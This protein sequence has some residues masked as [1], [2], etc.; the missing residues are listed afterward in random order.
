MKCSLKMHMYVVDCEFCLMVGFCQWFVCVYGC[1]FMCLCVS[2]FVW[3]AKYGFGCVCVCVCVSQRTRFPQ[4]TMFSMKDSGVWSQYTMHLYT[5]IW[6]KIRHCQCQCTYFR[7][8][9]QWCLANWYTHEKIIIISSSSTST[10]RAE[11]SSSKVNICISHSYDKRCTIR[12]IYQ[13]IIIIYKRIRI[14]CSICC[15]HYHYYYCY[16]LPSK[17]VLH[18]LCII[19]QPEVSSDTWVKSYDF[20]FL[21]PTHTINE[22]I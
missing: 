8:F 21:Y 13:E 3:T 18:S 17:C 15:Y 2:L 16:D 20:I 14:Q 6:I 12:N 19:L 22:S 7:I 5:W 4:Y 9:W 11:P 1:L 10:I